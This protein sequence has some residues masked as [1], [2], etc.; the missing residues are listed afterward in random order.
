MGRWTTVCERVGGWVA[1]GCWSVNSS[2]ATNVEHVLLQIY[3]WPDAR[4]LCACRCVCDAVTA[5]VGL[6]QWD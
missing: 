6:L 5:I 4:M 1:G 3:T 2:R